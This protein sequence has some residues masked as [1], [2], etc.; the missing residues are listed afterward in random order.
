[1]NNT[2]TVTATKPV[3]PPSSMPLAL[4]MYAVVVLVP[5]TAP[6]T[7]AR[8]SMANVRRARG[9]L[10][11]ASSTPALF[12][13]A[14][15]VPVASKKSTK[16]NVNTTAATPKPRA[17]CRSSAPDQTG[18]RYRQRDEAVRESAER[19]ER[20]LLTE[21]DGRAAQDRTECRGDDADQDRT[22]NAEHEQHR[23]EGQSGDRDQHARRR[24]RT[25]GDEGRRVGNDDPGVLEPDEREEHPDA[26]GDRVLQMKRHRAHD[27]LP[28]AQDAEHDEDA[29]RDRD[30]PERRLP[31]DLLSQDDGEGEIGVQAHTRRLRERIARDDTHQQAAD[32]GRER[33]HDQEL[34]EAVRDDDR[35][36]QHRRIDEQHVRHRQEVVRPARSSRRTLEPDEEMPK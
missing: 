30:R 3:R 25:E 11:F 27:R 15:N 12:A 21:I 10:P 4:S 19:D 14:T 5:R 22:R 9:M 18:R 20:A 31:W 13:S 33:G 2:P 16:K 29:A 8:P 6:I 7:A 34:R 28:H 23:G 26:G 36:A 32:R 35:V 17:A 1:M 24:E